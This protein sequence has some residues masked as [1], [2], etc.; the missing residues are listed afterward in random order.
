MPHAVSIPIPPVSRRIQY[1]FFKLWILSRIQHISARIRVRYVLDTDM[2]GSRKY[3]CF[4]GNDIR[5]NVGN[6]L[7]IV[8]G[9]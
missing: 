7:Q 9:S 4:I 6:K 3:P 8:L 2:A 1:I 5:R